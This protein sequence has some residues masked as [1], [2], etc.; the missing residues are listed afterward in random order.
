[1]GHLAI[2]IAKAVGAEV[3]TTVSARHRELARRMGADRIIAY[4]EE[5]FVAVLGRSM[6]VVFDMIGGEV[7]RRSYEVLVPGG[8]LVTIWGEPDPALE[9]QFSVTAST[10]VTLE[11]GDHLA[12]L[13]RLAAEG[14]LRP[15]V[16]REFPFSAAGAQ[17]AHRL[18]ESGHP[19]GKLVLRMNSDQ[20]R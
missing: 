20:P 12:Q 4:D 11:G 10:F 1:M 18:I 3:T 15:H 13:V 8:R 2:Q 16:A 6:D 7:L 19:G 14:R 17:A 5:D 9:A